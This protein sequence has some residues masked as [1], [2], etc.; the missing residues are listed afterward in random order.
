[1]AEILLTGRERAALLKLIATTTDA[2]L[3]RRAYAVLWLDEGESVTKVAAQLNASRQSV[4]NWCARFLERWDLPLV[5][6]LSDAART[7]RPVTV[8]GIID[9]VL[10]Q[11]IDTD[12]REVGYRATVWTV[13]LLVQYLT[14]QHQLTASAQSVRLALARLKIHW[15]RPRHRL[16]LRPGTWR[17]AKGG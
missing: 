5:T 1:M 6:R 13:P 9:P 16:A 2:R 8:Q 4:Y 15:K 10:D 11:V 3:L 7:G 14:D 12:P 17:Q